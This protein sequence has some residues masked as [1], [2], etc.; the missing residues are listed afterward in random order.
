MAGDSGSGKDHRI[1]VQLSCKRVQ[2]FSL[3]DTTC[4]VE[5]SDTWAATIH[6]LVHD[7]GHLEMSHNGSKKT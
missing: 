2:N 6:K 5:D 7:L 1:T 3:F 4:V